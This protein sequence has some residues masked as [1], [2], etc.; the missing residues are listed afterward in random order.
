M[1]TLVESAPLTQAAT[2]TTPA[3]AHRYRVRLIEGDR[4]GAS[5]YYSSGMLREHAGVFGAGTPMYLDHP[6]LSE[7]IERPERSVRDLAAY[8][9]TDAAYEGDGLYADIEV[10]PHVAPVIEAMRDHIGLSIRA[11]GTVEPSTDEAIRGPVVTSLTEAASVDFVTAAGAGGKI[12]ELLESARAQVAEAATVSNKPWSNFSASDYSIEQYRKACLISPDTP[13]DNKGDYQ[14]PV[15]EPDGTLNRNGVHAA[16]SVLAGGRGGVKAS[17]EQK[18]KAAQQ[19]VRLYGQLNEDPPDAVAKLAGKPQAKDGAGKESAQADW[20]GHYLTERYG[21]GADGVPLSEARNVGAWLEARIHSAFTCITDDMYGDGR[22]NREERIALS[23]AISDGLTAFTT[24]V[25]KNAPQ[26]YQ[27]DLWDGPPETQSDVSENQPGGAPGLTE[28]T[29]MAGSGASTNGGTDNNNQTDEEKRKQAEEEA[30]AAAAKKKQTAAKES[31]VTEA[32][33]AREQQLTEQ[34]AEAR[35]AN[36]ETT[37]RVAAL[38]ERLSAS[39]AK[40]QRLENEQAARKALDEA[41]KTA[42][43]PDYAHARIREAVTRDLPVDDKGVLD[44]EKF[45]EAA[46]AAIDAETSYITTVAEA[47]GAGKPRGLGGSPTS[48]ASEDIDAELERAF[49]GLGLSESAAKTA[50]TGR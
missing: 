7:G 36:E 38:E 37:A 26:L 2:T 9:V 17:A 45:A 15:R 11:S 34:L 39:D 16:A 1:T 18:R 27:R 42:G 30:A 43:L 50:A 3:G 35:K 49:A 10:Y 21:G 12:V 14:L 24:A 47:S 13:S 6:T 46:K 29:T 19:L 8:L 33:T 20:A 22:L 25:E 28:G 4:Q 44:A 40:A 41:L 23:S 32:A 31:E 48:Q 5:G